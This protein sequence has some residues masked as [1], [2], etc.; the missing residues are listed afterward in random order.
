MSDRSIAALW[1]LAVVLGL[2]LAMAVVAQAEPVPL[3]KEE[4]KKI[5]EAIDKGIDFL[6][7]MQSKNGSW[8]PHRQHLVGPVA[9][10]ALALLESGVPADDPAVQKAARWLRPHLPTLDKTYEVSLALIF[11]D[12]LGDPQDKS[13]IRSLGMRLIAGQRPSG[14]WDYGCPPLS[15]KTE[16]TLTNLLRQREEVV[17]D[18]KAPPAVP[19]AFKGLIVFHQH[20][21]LAVDSDNSNTQFATLALW[22]A[23]RQG[24]PVGPTLRLVAE[25]FENTQNPI[26]TWSYHIEQAQ[27]L[28]GDRSMTTVGLLALAVREGLRPEKK[29]PPGAPDAQVLRGFAAVGQVIGMRIALQ[30]AGSRG[31][32]C[33][34]DV[35]YL[36]S[37]E[38]IAMLYD[39]PTIG[40][41]DWYRWGAEYLLAN[42]TRFGEFGPPE[43][44][45]YGESAVNTSFA[46]LF[47]KRSHL[48]QD[49]TAKL[50][51]KSEV[52]EKGIA[53]ALQGGGVPAAPAQPEASPKKP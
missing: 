15:A 49:L 30:A 23:R 50:P 1:D 37:L 46:L 39:L 13:A 34:R 29:A 7:R 2:V 28:V 38:R 43:R 32:L 14:G 24:L 19:A 17:G 45:T 52:L 48:L 9:L 33:N 26:G 10:S 27:N 31:Q 22:V 8:T 36:W 44:R 6:K 3:S 42:Q 21:R 5:D 51:Y 41:K 12:R 11:F 18:N 53:G 25:R 20:V 4:Q 47:L 35:Y 16:D 40:G